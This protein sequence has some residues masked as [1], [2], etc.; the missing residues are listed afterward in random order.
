MELLERASQL[1]ALNSALAQAKSGQGCV[2]LVYGEAGIGKTSVVDSF[3][4]EHK[5]SWRILSGACD[6]LFTPRPLG[7]LHDIASQTQGSL[8]ALLEAESNRTAI[9]SACLNELNTQ[10]TILVIEDIH[11]ADEATLDLLKYLGRRIRQ[12]A[13]LMVLT[14]RDDEIGPDH[15]LRLLLGD[16]ASSHALHRVPI[17]PLSKDAVQNLAKG[18]NVNSLE[19]HRMTNGNPF[20]VTEVLAVESGIPETVRD[21]VLARAARLSAA[22]R[23]V[24]EAAAVIGSRAEAWLLSN[25]IGSESVNIE[26]CTARGMLLSQGDVYAFRHELARQTILETTSSQKKIALHR[27]TLTALKESSETRNDLARLANH[28]AGAKDAKAVLEYAPAASKQASAL[29]A[30]RQAAAHYKTALQYVGKSD[31][32]LRAELLDA[33]ADEC[34]LLDQRVIAKQAQEEALEIWQELGRREKEGRAFRRLSEID[35]DYLFSPKREQNVAHAIE[36]LETLPPSKE[37]AR[38]YGQMARVHLNLNRDSGVD[39][40][41]WGSRAIALAEELQD[42]ETLVHALN[43]IG[44][45]EFALGR[46]DAGQPK[47]ERSLQLALKHDLQFHVARAYLNLARELIHSR[48]YA[49]S[50]RY[51]KEGIEYCIQHDLDQ[52]YMPFLIDRA[53]IRL[54]QG[55]WAEAEQDIQTVRK[56]RDV[57]DSFEILVVMSLLSKIQMLRGD[58]LSVEALNTMRE[59]VPKTSA[60]QI[61]CHI[62]AFFAQLA[63]LSGNLEQCRAEAEPTYKMALQLDYQPYGVD[64]SEFSELSYWMWRVGAITEP[65]AIVIE[66]YA[67]QIR[68]NWREAAAMWEK[69]G[70]PYEQGMALMDGDETAQ[71]AALE[72]FERLGARPIIE[73]LKKQ[74][75]AQGIRIPRGPRPATRENPFGLTAREMDILSCLTNG[76]SNHAI[77]KQLSLST[78]TVEHHISSILKKMEVQSRNEAVARAS[79]EKLFPSE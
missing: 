64:D 55:Y 33:Y 69:F 19:L 30:H 7:P 58:H 4:R 27:R 47:M 57:D 54:Q 32:E 22:A 35:H 26:E 18:K 60:M 2:T 21:A 29:G 50:L 16:L 36:L 28:A 68:G 11:W 8:G 72:I 43:T 31:P 38:A 25:F 70:C 20:F 74:M 40:L 65:M 71:L 34:Y 23:S 6:S 67:S 79:K 10:S 44:T 56:Q 59:A 76:L 77:A 75:R 5:K 9:F 17:S 37:L 24:L 46:R 42:V 14:Y 78:R 15:P 49:T 53:D 63:W 48:D 3:A 41:Y 62:A 52:W 13:S 1:L 45:A 66:P 51:N 12:T 39:P 73:I 61:K